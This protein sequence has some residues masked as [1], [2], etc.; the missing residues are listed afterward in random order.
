MAVKKN[1]TDTIS[2]KDWN[3]LIR[4]ARKANPGQDDVTDTRA[5][6]RR[7]TAS[8]QKRNARWN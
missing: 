7:M 6:R 8:E 5:I 4:R 3:S 2:D 1:T